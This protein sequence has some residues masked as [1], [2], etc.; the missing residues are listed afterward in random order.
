MT[1]ENKK[2]TEATTE[3][4]ETTVITKTPTKPAKSLKRK[5]NA[6]RPIY[7]YDFNGNLV[8]R[9]R[10]PTD[11]AKRLLGYEKEDAEDVYDSHKL[12][13]LRYEISTYA[14]SNANSHN[15]VTFVQ[16][17]VPSYKELSSTDIIGN[18]RTQT[19]R[20]NRVLQYDFNGNLIRVFKNAG[21]AAENLGKSTAW[22]SI[23]CNADFILRYDR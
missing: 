4:H 22:V 16:G 1:E 2:N 10:G 12:S 15:G 21:D 20:G 23:L 6:N 19:V 3:N 7:L 9:F 8:G 17:Y 13:N 18:R 14:R 11:A 5:M